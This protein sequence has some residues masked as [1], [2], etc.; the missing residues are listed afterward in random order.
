M[1][2]EKQP[3]RALPYSEEASSA[4]RPADL[5]CHVVFAAGVGL[6]LGGASAIFYNIGSFF[7][8]WYPHLITLGGFMAALVVSL[9]WGRVLK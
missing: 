2:A 8:E 5:V 6:V 7:M 9:R 1:D 4:L 3:V